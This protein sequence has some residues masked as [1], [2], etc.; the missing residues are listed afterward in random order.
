MRIDHYT[1]IDLPEVI[2][3]SM[4]NIDRMDKTDMIFT[5]LLFS[6]FIDTV[7]DAHGSTGVTSLLMFS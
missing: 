3:D 6:M 7:L 2:E 1:V 5:I 4:K